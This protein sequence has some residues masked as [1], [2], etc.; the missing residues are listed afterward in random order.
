MR[1]DDYD[2]REQ[3]S[4][5]L[6][7]RLAAQSLPEQPGLSTCGYTQARL[8]LTARELQQART[9]LRLIAASLPTQYVRTTEP[10]EP[11]MDLR[12]TDLHADVLKRL[13]DGPV[14]VNRA[15]SAATTGAF[16]ELQ[17]AGVVC[18]DLADADV[19]SIRAD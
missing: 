15:T 7:A 4:D 19:W 3:L 18:R 8:I 10:E 2:L 1:T 14:K 9:S 11:C 16:F 13:L 17:A 6:L 12:I 5:E